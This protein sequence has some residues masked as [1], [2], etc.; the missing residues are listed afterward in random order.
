MLNPSDCF[1]EQ[2]I[3]DPAVSPK[4]DIAGVANRGLFLKKS[5]E[6]KFIY[7]YKYMYS[8]HSYTCTCTVFSLYTE[9]LFHVNECPCEALFTEDEDGKIKL[10]DDNGN[11]HHIHVHTCTRI[12]MYMYM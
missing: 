5:D 2:V 6:G 12:H 1:S 11:I 7:Y 8:V 3:E 10:C 9:L 4:L